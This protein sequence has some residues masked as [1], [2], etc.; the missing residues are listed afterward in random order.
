ML[1]GNMEYIQFSVN[2]I[3]KITQEQ[4]HKQIVNSYD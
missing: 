4:K 2:K 1:F 3:R